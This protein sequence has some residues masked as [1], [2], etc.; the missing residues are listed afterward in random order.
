MYN[1]IQIIPFFLVAFLCN[2]IGLFSYYLSGM[3]KKRY[4]PN[5]EYRHP[6][7]WY[8]NLKKPSL[9]PPNSLFAPVW[10]ILYTAMGIGGLLIV[11]NFGLVSI[12]FMLFLV[13]LTFNFM[14]CIVFF[15]WNQ[16]VPSLS[17]II[18]VDFAYAAMLLVIFFNFCKKLA[19]ISPKTLKDAA[20]IACILISLVPMFLVPIF[21]NR[22]FSQISQ[23]SV[24]LILYII[25]LSL[26]ILLFYI[27]FRLNIPEIYSNLSEETALMIMLCPTMFWSLFATHLNYQIYKLNPPQKTLT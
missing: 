7:A 11:L 23:S 5:G 2:G 18:V 21:K 27:S 19:N 3:F 15:K 13:Q 4:F 12:P 22:K 14:W 17:V 10:T 1:L 9:W 24:T 8:T 26:S 16:I 20:F 25:S 6:S